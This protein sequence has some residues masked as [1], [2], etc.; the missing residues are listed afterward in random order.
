MSKEKEFDIVEVKFSLE[1]SKNEK[2][3]TLYIESPE[4][5]DLE[6][7]F[8]TLE[9]LIMDFRHEHGFISPL[10]DAGDKFH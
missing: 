6:D 8:N 3:Y 2:V 10:M 1:V 4:K 9:Q 7:Y 5:M